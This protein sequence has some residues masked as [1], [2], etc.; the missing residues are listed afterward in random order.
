MMDYYIV[1]KIKDN[2]KL[3]FKGRLLYER[4]KG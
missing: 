4:N 2:C 1:I 3:W